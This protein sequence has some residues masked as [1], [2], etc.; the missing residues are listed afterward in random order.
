MN[1]RTIFGIIIVLT[2]AF[3]LLSTALAHAELVSSDP[4]AGAKLTKAPAKIA[5]VFSEEIDD[6]GSS[7]TITDAKKAT[8]GTGK[9]DLNDLD[10]KTLIGTLNAGAGDGVYTVAWDVITADDKAEESGTFTFGVNTD[11]GAQPTA[12]PEEEATAVA[13][14]AATPA[15]TTRPTTAA[16]GAA[17]PTATPATGAGPAK[18]PTTGDTG[19]DRSSYLIGVAILLVAAGVALWRGKRSVR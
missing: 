1:R 6:Q 5:L 15:A 14:A 16:A 3:G 11:P 10:H 7:F 19:T 2:L 18:L 9:L 8:V 13:T 4:A 12:A 17:Q